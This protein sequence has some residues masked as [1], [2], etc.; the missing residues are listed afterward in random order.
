MRRAGCVRPLAVGATLGRL[1]AAVVRSSAV[2]RTAWCRCRCWPPSSGFCWRAPG[3]AH[4][5]EGRAD[6]APRRSPAQFCSISVR[7]RSPRPVVT[8]WAIMLVLAVGC[9]L[10]TRRLA[11]RPDGARRCSSSSSPA[12]RGQIEEIIRKDAAA[13]PAVARH[14]VHLSGGGQ[15]LGVLPGV[16]APT[17]KLETPAA[18][19]LIVFFSVHYF[20]VRARGLARLSRELRQ[21]E[22]HHAAAQYPLGGDAHLLADGAPVRQCDERR[23]RD[24]AG[25]GARRAVRADPA[26]GARDPGRPG[27]GLHLHRARNRLHRRRRRQWSRTG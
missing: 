12:S 4:G 6:A 21:A 1:A 26:H 11:L 27:A 24:R 13:V 20:G 7:S 16:E 8:T 14:A 25:R 19:A 22:A 18:L 10:V 17:G 5:A 9:W 15:S 3:V 23:I 2:A